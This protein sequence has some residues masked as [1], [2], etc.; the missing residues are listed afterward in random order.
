LFEYFAKHKLGIIAVAAETG[1]P[2][3]V[4]APFL[5][6]DATVR[7]EVGRTIQALNFAPLPSISAAAAQ[8]KRD[9][10]SDPQEPL[11]SS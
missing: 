4:T 3:F 5:L 7:V 10:C 9:Y 2:D 6:S 11:D 1:Q 8:A